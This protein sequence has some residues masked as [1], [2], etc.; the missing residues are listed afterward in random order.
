MEKILLKARVSTACARPSGQWAMNTATE[1]WRIRIIT[2]IVTKAPHYRDLLREDA[3]EFLQHLLN[4]G[5]QSLYL[6]S[7][8]L[9]GAIFDIVSER[10]KQVGELLQMAE[11]GFGYV[12]SP[13][14]LQ[15][16]YWG[17]SSRFYEAYRNYMIS[18][19]YLGPQF[20]EDRLALWRSRMRIL[21]KM[22]SKL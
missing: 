21:N 6:Q 20:W 5:S 3:W 22:L 2:A 14:Y 9:V 12:G 19:N 15:L 7:H 1:K 10:L 17:T 8:A 4:R 11:Q 16:E 18:K 13:V